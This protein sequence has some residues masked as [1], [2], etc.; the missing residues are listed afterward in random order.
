MNDS[1]TLAMNAGLNLASIKQKHERFFNAVYESLDAFLEGY[2]ARFFD[3]GVAAFWHEEGNTYLE[4][5]GDM[6]SEVVIVL[7]AYAEDET[8]SRVL[9]VSASTEAAARRESDERGTAGVPAPGEPALVAAPRF[10]VPG[11]IPSGDISEYSRSLRQL[12]NLASIARR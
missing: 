10:T 12:Q 9:A 4:M 1:H 7:G 8:V 5:M 3:M 11:Y 2:V 6:T